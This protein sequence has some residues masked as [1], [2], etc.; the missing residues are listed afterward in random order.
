M[1][2]SS[3]LVQ[4]SNFISPHT[5]GILWLTD[6]PLNTK[7]NCVYE[8][9]YLTNGLLTKSIQ[10]KESMTKPNA[11]FFVTKSFGNPFFLS[12][13]VISEKED[14]KN[15]YNHIEMAKP[16]VSEK[17][18]EVYIFNRSSNTRNFNILKELTKRYDTIDFKTLNL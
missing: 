4:L 8:F 6:E 13:S 10:N 15:I 11:N 16:L 17:V 2:H 14:I 1:K 12:H 9:N 3:L 7:L 5:A 18:N